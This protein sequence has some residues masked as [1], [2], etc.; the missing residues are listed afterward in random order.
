MN[1]LLACPRCPRVVRQ[2]H[3]VRY[4]IGLVDHERELMCDEDLLELRRRAS[5]YEAGRVLDTASD[6]VWAIDVVRTIG[7]EP[8]PGRAP[9]AGASTTRPAQ[10]SKPRRTRA[11]RGA[12]EV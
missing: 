5:E 10:E 7:T 2:L 3:E 4:A 1:D 6:G 9:A 12:V 8:E 11:A